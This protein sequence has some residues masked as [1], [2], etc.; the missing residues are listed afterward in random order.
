M[1]GTCSERIKEKASLCAPAMRALLRPCAGNSCV[2][3]F[4]CDAAT[5]KML[6]SKE[7]FAAAAQA[8]PGALFVPGNPTWKPSTK[9]LPLR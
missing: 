9:K 6:R 3:A 7:T 8:A 2:T 4:Y 1:T 5:E